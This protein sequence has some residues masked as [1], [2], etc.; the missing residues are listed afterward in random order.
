DYIRGEIERYMIARVCPSCQGKR[1]KPESLA[2]VI[3]GR[4]II[5]VTDTSIA[6]ASEWIE[7]LLKDR[8]LS[9]REL[10]IDTQIVKELQARLKFLLDVGLDYLTLERNASTLSG[11]EAQ[12]IRLASQIGSGLSGVLYVLDERSIG[13]H[14]SD[15][16][17][18]I[19][20]LKELRE[21]GNTVIVVEHDDETMLASD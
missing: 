6:K 8:R 18:L 10:M 15:N 2:V 13:L 12:R 14:Q 3:D 1:L 9:D 21:L 17:K 19:T 16:A 11:G 7:G 4:S 5:E 20:T